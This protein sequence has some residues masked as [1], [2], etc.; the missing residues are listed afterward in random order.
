MAALLLYDT[1]DC[2]SGE[3][4]LNVAPGKQPWQAAGGAAAAATVA[5][6][7][8]AAAAAEVHVQLRPQ[9]G[10]LQLQ[11]LQQLRPQKVAKQGLLAYS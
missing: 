11:Q 9:K 1:R 3:A 10:L 6:A 4:V 2:A 7:A 8:A 5:V